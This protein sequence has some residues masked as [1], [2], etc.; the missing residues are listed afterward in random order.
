LRAANEILSTKI[1]W[2]RV[3]GIV[4]LSLK[5]YI[6]KIR[7][8]FNINNSKLVSTPLESHLRLTKD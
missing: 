6:K 4:K 5:N 1:I 7:N 2:E 3:E 8:M